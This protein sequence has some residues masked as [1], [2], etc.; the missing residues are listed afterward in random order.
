MGR[1]SEIGPGER[2]I[3]DANG[4]S[5]GIFNVHGTYHAL[6]NSC[7]HQA[8]PLCLRSNKGMTLSGKPDEYVWSREGEILRCPSH[9][10]EF[11][12]TTGRSI[13]NPHKTLVKAY[14]VTVESTLDGDGESIETFPVTV[15]D[16]WI[17]LHT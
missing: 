16:D 13:F 2:R 6:R 11:D 12:I 7:P 10:R 4:R 1:T 14:D 3:V 5:I 8:V 15:E 9:G 17:V